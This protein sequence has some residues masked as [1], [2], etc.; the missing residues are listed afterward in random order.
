MAYI[1][2]KKMYHIHALGNK[3]ELWQIGN[4]I[5]NSNEEFI[6]I[7][8]NFTR[9][10]HLAVKNKNDEQ[11]KYSIENSADCELFYAKLKKYVEKLKDTC[12][13]NRIVE[14]ILEE[15]RKEW[16]SDLPSRYNCIWLCSEKELP[17]WKEI[18]NNVLGN[19][20]KIFEV[21]VTGE[22]FASSD[23][24]LPYFDY[25]S[26]N[27][28]QWAYQD[29]YKYWNASLDDIDEEQKEYLFVGKIHIDNKLGEKEYEKTKRIKI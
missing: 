18:L 8:N 11:Y 9:E 19:R 10:Q 7:R 2:N 5:D 3:D 4:T 27:S 1:E 28:I 23:N 17:F 15:V 26:S 12:F 21:T 25:K 22:I 20:F 13:P 24:L 16:F 29:A 14:M 6:N